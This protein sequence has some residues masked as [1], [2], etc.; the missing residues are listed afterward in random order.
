[1]KLFL[2]RPSIPV[3]SNYNDEEVLQA[4]EKQF[5]NP[6]PVLRLLMQR[7]ERLLEAVGDQ[8]RATHIQQRCQ[9]EDEDCSPVTCPACGEPLTVKDGK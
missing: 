3:A 1:M 9:E 6:P 4:A 5:A 8:E 2:V 7:Y